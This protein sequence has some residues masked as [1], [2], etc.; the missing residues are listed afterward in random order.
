MPRRTDI[1]T[2]RAGESTAAVRVHRSSTLQKID[3]VALADGL[4]VTAIA[5]TLIDLASVLTPHQLER[6][7]HRAEFL[8]ILDVSAF[9]ATGCPRALRKALDSLV[10][11]SPELT[12]SELEERMLALIAR[13]GLPRPLVNKPVLTHEVDFHW[14]EQRLIVEVDGAAAHLTPTAFEEDR[15]RDAELQVAGWRV[16]RFT[17][18]Q[19]RDDP[20]AVARALRALLS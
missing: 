10:A 8:R 14:P 20:D 16:V 15:R 7:C 13:H 11:R 6:V 3:I 9:P 12:R 5:R 4:R 17:W 1:L 19:L 2:L 18:R